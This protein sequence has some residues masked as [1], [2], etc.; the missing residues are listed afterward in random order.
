VFRA[1]C[2]SPLF[3]NKFEGV[4]FEHVFPII[5]DPSFFEDATTAC[6]AHEPERETLEEEDLETFVC[7]PVFQK[8][9]RRDI[10]LRKKERKIC[11]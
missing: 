11:I 1:F 3:T 10:A 8:E 5:I 6:A 2:R 4:V 7:D 9:E